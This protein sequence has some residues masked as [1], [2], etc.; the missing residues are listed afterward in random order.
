MYDIR[1]SS[2]RCLRFGDSM[3]VCQEVNTRGGSSVTSF[4]PDDEH[5]KKHLNASV[6][7]GA[8]I[9]WGFKLPDPVKK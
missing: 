3:L 7:A 6:V 1:C 8:R 9:L 4:G 2:L 5:M